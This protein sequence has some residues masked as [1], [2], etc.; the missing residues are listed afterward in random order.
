MRLFEVIKTH[1]IYEGVIPSVTTQEAVNKS[2]FGPVYHGSTPEKLEKIKNTGFKIIKAPT[3]S[4]GVS[5]GYPDEP[6]HGG[7]SPPMHHLGF[8]VY[9][10][11]VKAIGKRFNNDSERGLFQYYLDVPRK[12]TINFAA[13]GTMMKWWQANGF[14][15]ADGVGQYKAT[16]NLTHELSS[17]YDAVWFKGKTMYRTLDGDQVCVYDPR[18]IY[19]LDNSAVGGHDLGAMVKIEQ[20]MPPRY[21]GRED[22]YFMPGPNI[23]GKIIRKDLIPYDNFDPERLALM[24]LDP[25]K[26]KNWI[27]VTW[28][29]GGTHLNYT[30]QDLV[31]LQ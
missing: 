4:P 24:K 29:H 2:M 9:F 1:N 22:Q 15:I 7:F 12:E 3:G 25:A 10:T 27:S 14:N 8:G 19:I 6:Y 11:T 28:S 5:H 30:E 26:D 20:W 31:P 18:R 17:K 21:E 23:K 16:E 13:T